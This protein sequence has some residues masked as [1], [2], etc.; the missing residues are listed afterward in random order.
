MFQCNFRFA[1]WKF[2]QGLRLEPFSFFS[3]LIKWIFVFLSK[4]KTQF[5]E[6]TVIL[7]PNIWSIDVIK[8][9]KIIFILISNYQLLL[10]IYIIEVWASY[11][12]YIGVSPKRKRRAPKPTGISSI[13]IRFASTRPISTAKRSILIEFSGKRDGLNWRLRGNSIGGEGGVQVSFRVRTFV[14]SFVLDYSSRLE[15]PIK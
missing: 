12:Y 7:L 10:D 14:R 8:K 1:L 3:S 5:K 13:L 6:H 9:T 4:V 11:R 15:P 2:L